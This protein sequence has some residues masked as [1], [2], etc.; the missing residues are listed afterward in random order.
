MGVKDDG[1]PP[2][3]STANVDTYGM[4]AKAPSSTEKGG[5]ALDAGGV[6]PISYHIY[7]TKALGVSLNVTGDD[8]DDVKFFLEF[9]IKF[10][11]GWHLTLHRGDNKNGPVVSVLHRNGA[12]G[13]DIELTLADG[14]TT[15][16][17]RKN[18]FSTNIHFRAPK[19]GSV[20]QWTKE[21]G[22][23]SKDYTVRS[24]SLECSE[25]ADHF[26]VITD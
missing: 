23:L 16:L 7:K 14:F 12:L 19:Q 8:K 13:T 22:L 11:G 24:V 21:K 25:A 20:Y 4:D 6:L 10:S 26:S 15:T 5:R 1:G 2:S 3:Y 18:Y 17:S 9:P